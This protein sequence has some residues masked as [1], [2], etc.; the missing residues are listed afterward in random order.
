MV[1]IASVVLVLALFG[2]TSDSSDPVA[3]VGTETT[4]E[5]S[6]SVPVESGPL[7]TPSS[8]PTAT[9]TPSPTFAPITKTCPDG[10]D[11]A[12]MEYQYSPSEMS[13]RE[14]VDTY[15]GSRAPEYETCPKTMRNPDR[16]YSYDPDEQSHIDAIAEFCGGEKLEWL[17]FCRILEPREAQRILKGTQSTIESCYAVEISITQFDAN[18]GP[19]SFL[20]YFNEPGASYWDSNYGPQPSGLF[21][22]TENPYFFSD[23]TDCPELD[24]IF[25]NDRVVAA[26]IHLGPLTYT[27]ISQTENTVPA[28][29]MVFVLSPTRVE[30]GMLNGI[31]QTLQTWPLFCAADSLKREV[32]L[33]GIVADSDLN[34]CP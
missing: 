28:F 25:E 14:A 20:G 27:T 3:A 16:E 5:S 9:A 26:A 30:N 21:G 29:Q 15:C 23:Y 18:T 11:N 10:R 33:R 24:S 8:V 1:R 2:C 17:E 12:G 4:A 31:R 34:H 7:S 19:C 6:E 32:G 13:S 22:Y